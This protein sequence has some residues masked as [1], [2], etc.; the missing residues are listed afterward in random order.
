[1]LSYTEVELTAAVNSAKT[2]R[3]LRYML[4]GL[5]FTQEY[6]AP[7]Y[8]EDDPTIESFQVQIGFSFPFLLANN[9]C[10]SLLIMR[11]RSFL[12]SCT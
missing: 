12:L 9:L 5:G 7:I 10:S 4:R 3:F 11:T 6:Q 1:M 8:E 2:T